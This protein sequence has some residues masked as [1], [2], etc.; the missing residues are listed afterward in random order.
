MR[1]DTSK[2]EIDEDMTKKTSNSK[3]K[4]ECKKFSAQQNIETKKTKKQSMNNTFV[5]S[6]HKLIFFINNFIILT[7]TFVILLEN[8]SASTITF[9]SN[10]S[11]FKI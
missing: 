5:F 1:L 8:A 7:D 6:Y 10:T 3:L 4:K 11:H 2:S 9:I